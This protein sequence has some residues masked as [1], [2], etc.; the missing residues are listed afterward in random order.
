MI[1]S[2]THFQ[3]VYSS[4][5]SWTYIEFHIIWSSC[6]CS[7]HEPAHTI[8]LGYTDNGSFRVQLWYTGN[9]YIKDEPAHMISFDTHTE[10]ISKMNLT[11]T[12]L[13]CLLSFTS[14]KVQVRVL[15]MNLFF[16]CSALVHRQWLFQRWT[17]SYDKLW[18][19]DWDYFKDELDNRCA[20]MFL[21][22]KVCIPLLVFLQ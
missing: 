20:A 18:Y 13:L 19:T 10:T 17:R 9:D 3:M 21:K 22:N 16:Q 2:A 8:S 4:E 5:Y 11:I 7:E 14:S 6:A 15:N 1:F 12:V